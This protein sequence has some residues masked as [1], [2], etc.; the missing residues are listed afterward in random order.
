MRS[1]ATHAHHC[2][3]VWYGVVWCGVVWCGGC[4]VVRSGVVWC[5]LVVLVLPVLVFQWRVAGGYVRGRGG[6]GSGSVGHTH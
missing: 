6:A 5:G 4:G 3:V 2:A 1:G